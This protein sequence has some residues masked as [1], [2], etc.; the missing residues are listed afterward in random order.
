MTL[1]N[2]YEDSKQDRPYTLG[3]YIGGL[4][5]WLIWVSAYIGIIYMGWNFVAKIFQLPQLTYLQVVTIII[6]GAFVKGLYPR[7]L[8]ERY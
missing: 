7:N 5:I 8:N 3:E 2:M 6:W 4:I 1:K